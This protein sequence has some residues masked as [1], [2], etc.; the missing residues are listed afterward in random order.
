MAEQFREQFI[1]PISAALPSPVLV[2]KFSIRNDGY[3]G[4]SPS[5]WV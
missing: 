4:D 2:D 1:L 5:E 3:Q